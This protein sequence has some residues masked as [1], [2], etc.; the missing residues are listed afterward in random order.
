ME[1]GAGRDRGGFAKFPP[2]P[3]KLP[4]RGT[5]K[6]KIYFSLSA[7]LFFVKLE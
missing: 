7:L 1:E 2:F 5:R 3:L 4:N 6:G